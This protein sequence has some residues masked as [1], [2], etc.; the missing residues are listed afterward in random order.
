MYRLLLV[1]AVCVPSS[2]Y[3][4]GIQQQG[5]WQGDTSK[6]VLFIHTGP[7]RPD[8]KV[9]KRIAGALAQKGYL[10]RA[11]DGQQDNVGGPGV[12]YFADTALDAA[13]D[14]AKTVNDILQKEMSRTENTL[15]P[16]RQ[17]TKNPATYLGV[18]LF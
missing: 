6:F 18:W 13:K 2:L 12:D 10:V 9:V 4:Q 16:R 3:A 14:V 8:D 15:R 7:R 1:L 5:V 11:P 17:R